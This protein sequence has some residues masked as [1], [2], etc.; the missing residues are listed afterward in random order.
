M[1]NGN[2]ATE[3]EI[4]TGIVHDVEDNIVKVGGRKSAS[5]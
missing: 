5:Y 3:E 2:L 1:C 4:V